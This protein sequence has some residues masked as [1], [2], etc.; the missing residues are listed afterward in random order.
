MRYAT[1]MIAQWWLPQLQRKFR[2]AG[3]FHKVWTV[4]RRS[5]VYACPSW[6]RVAL[7]ARSVISE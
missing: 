2:I 4:Q 3:D 6:R 1:G 7:T 5:V